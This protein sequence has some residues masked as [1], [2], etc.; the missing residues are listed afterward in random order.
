MQVAA[1]CAG[2]KRYLVG[3]LG[4]WGN[5]DAIEVA[6]DF[7][8]VNQQGRGL[9][10]KWTGFKKVQPPS[11]ADAKEWGQGTGAKTR[12]VEGATPGAGGW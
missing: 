5:V 12:P 3:C 10:V 9:V 4:G 1:A 8:V 11:E 7:E 6:G 2:S